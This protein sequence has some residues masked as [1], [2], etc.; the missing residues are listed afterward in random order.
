MVEVVC[1]IVRGKDGKVLVCRRN[2]EKHLGGKWEFPGGKIDAGETGGEALTRELKEELAIDVKIGKELES[3]V[4]W[5]DGA[6][7]IRLRAFHC[8]IAY[9][10]PDALEHEEIRWLELSELVGLDWAEA[11]LPFI[12]ELIGN[13]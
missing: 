4:E 7:E 11:D 5:A 10:V 6:V 13:R 3:C 12:E 2:F 1:G 8:E 9:G